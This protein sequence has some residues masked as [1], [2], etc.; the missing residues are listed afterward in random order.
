[1]IIKQIK[2]INNKNEKK[3]RNIK[4]LLYS[5]EISKIYNVFVDK[6]KVFK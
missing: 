4:M 3:G 6:L 2:N 1:M 5:M